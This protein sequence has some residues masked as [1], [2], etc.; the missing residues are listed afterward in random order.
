[1]SDSFNIRRNNLLN[2]TLTELLLL[3]LF[4][5]LLAS[6]IMLINYKKK[7]DQLEKERDQLYVV[8]KEQGDKIEKLEEDNASL[9]AVVEQILGKEY[10]KAQIEELIGKLELANELKNE[11]ENL[12]EEVTEL[13]EENSKLQQ[14]IDAL[15]ENEKDIATLKDEL[16]Q[17]SEENEILKG[18]NEAIIEENVTLN[19]NIEQVSEI[20]EI[21]SKYDQA[22][23]EM[24]IEKINNFAGKVKLPCWIDEEKGK[25]E[26]IF[27]IF[28]E[29]EGIRIVKDIPDYRET[30]YNN[31]P[32]NNLSFNK[33]YQPEE[34][35]NIF[36]GLKAYS[37]QNECNFYIAYKNNLKSNDPQTKLDRYLKAVESAFYKYEKRDLY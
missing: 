17:L 7:I 31:L 25:E 36:R 22:Q 2:F 19:E 23:Q 21:L 18:E 13:T 14:I 10:S 34:F 12:R 8:V 9:R 1:M 29:T 28:F 4:L 11:V 32:L 33:Y 5:I 20:I 35:I 6:S 30:D 24:I 16:E 37:D 15:D 27:N 26:Y 3:L